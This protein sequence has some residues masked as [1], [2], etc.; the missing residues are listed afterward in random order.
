MQNEPTRMGDETSVS[1]EGDHPSFVKPLIRRNLLLFGWVVAVLWTLWHLFLFLFPVRIF[2]PLQILAVPYFV[3]LVR[4][5]RNRH[6]CVQDAMWL[7]LSFL[8]IV[9]VEVYIGFV[10]PQYPWTYPTEFMEH[11]FGV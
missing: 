11:V 4:S 5:S 1:S 7:P 8:P 2:T 10:Y 9:A 3:I 6:L